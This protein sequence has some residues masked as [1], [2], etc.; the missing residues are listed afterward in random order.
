MLFL[1]DNDGYTKAQSK[2]LPRE[3]ASEVYRKML[4]DGF[5][6][7]KGQIKTVS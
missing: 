3:K 6:E 5:I 4:N 1:C 2:P 7:F